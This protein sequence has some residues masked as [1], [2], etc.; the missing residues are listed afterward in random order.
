MEGFQN[1]FQKKRRASGAF[2]GKDAQI[3]AFKEESYK[4]ARFC[5]KVRNHDVQGRL[6]RPG[7]GTN[8]DVPGQ[9]TFGVKK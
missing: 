9:I 5:Q 8:H 4:T 7:F 2:Y 6:K 1:G 3:A